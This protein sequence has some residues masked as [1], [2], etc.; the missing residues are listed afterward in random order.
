MATLE[1]IEMAMRRGRWTEGARL[2]RELLMG[3]P[4]D[5]KIH[6]YE[7]LCFFRLGQFDQAEPCFMRATALDPKFVDAGVKR[8]QCL[9]RMRRYDEALTLAREWIVQ[10]PNDPALNAIVDVHQYR[11]NPRRTEGWEISAQSMGR[12]HFASEL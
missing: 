7:G 9:D 11:A 10:R 5:A 8:C 4:T 6:A 12:A 2:S 1:E 3:R